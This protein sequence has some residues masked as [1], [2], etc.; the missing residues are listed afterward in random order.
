MDPALVHRRIGLVSKSPIVMLVQATK[1][2]EVPPFHDSPQQSDYVA[3]W[4]G[5]TPPPRRSGFRRA[6][7]RVFIT[8]PHFVRWRCLGH[9]QRWQYSLSNKYFYTKL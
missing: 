5:N 8:L 1:K 9:Y 3:A 6:L 7:K 2:K 4:N